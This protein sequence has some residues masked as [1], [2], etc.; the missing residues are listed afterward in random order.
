MKNIKTHLNGIYV[1]FR[2]IT[3]PLQPEVFCVLVP[4][5]LIVLYL[6]T[7]FKK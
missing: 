2:K 6:T 3:Y 7:G 4:F 5:V 1:E